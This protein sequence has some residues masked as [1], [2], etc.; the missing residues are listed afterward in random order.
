[1]V[2]DIHH[3]VSLIGQPCIGRLRGTRHAAQKQSDSETNP[4]Q[5]GRTDI[6][7]TIYV[8]HRGSN[9]CI[10]AL[11]CQATSPGSAWAGKA[12]SW[13]FCIRRH[14]QRASVLKFGSP[15]SSEEVKVIYL[16]QMLLDFAGMRG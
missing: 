9:L 10:L 16:K 1:V 12:T 13:R 2:A 3:G 14:A 6:N 8:R 5:D 7:E 4:K 15:R 11:F